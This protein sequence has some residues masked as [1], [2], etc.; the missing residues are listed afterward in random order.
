MH[1]ISSRFSIGESE[2]V[3][4]TAPVFPQYPD[5]VLSSVICNSMY[6]YFLIIFCLFIQ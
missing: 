4:V 3:Q 1:Y 6:L 2:N 5:I